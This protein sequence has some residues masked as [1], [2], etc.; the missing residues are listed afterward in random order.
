MV[1][2]LLGGEKVRPFWRHYYQGT[3]AVI[4]VVDSASPYDEMEEA[5]QALSDALSNLT[6]RSLPCL[7]LANCQDKKDARTEQQVRI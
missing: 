1:S 6:L 7:V 2:C 3:Q 4:F 5:K